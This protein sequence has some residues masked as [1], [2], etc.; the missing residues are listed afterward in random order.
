MNLDFLGA[1]RTHLLC[2]HLAKTQ[3]TQL[4]NGQK[5]VIDIFQKM[6]KKFMKYNLN[7]YKKNCMKC[8]MSLII[9]EMQIKITIRYHF[10]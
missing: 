9:R 10:T 1:D 2:P 6:T 4:E 8:S 3:T 5:T 7:I